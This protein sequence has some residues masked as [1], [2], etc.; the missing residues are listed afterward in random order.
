MAMVFPM[1]AETERGLIFARTKETLRARQASS[2]PVGRSKGPG[3]SKLDKH[4]PEI[5][6]L[7]A[8]GQPRSSSRSATNPRLPTSQTG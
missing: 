3:K 4:R 7:F 8:N 6:A 2:W 5:E 1:A